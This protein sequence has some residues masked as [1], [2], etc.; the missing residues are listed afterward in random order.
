MSTLNVDNNNAM[1]G[2]NL[3][4]SPSSTTDIFTG[5]TN[6]QEIFSWKT[7]ITH[8]IAR[9]MPPLNQQRFLTYPKRA[10][11]VN[12][13][14]SI[15]MDQE[16]LSPQKSLQTMVLVLGWYVT[17][18]ATCDL[19]S[20]RRVE[21]ALQ[22]IA[23]GKADRIIFSGG[24]NAKALGKGGLI[25]EAQAMLDY[26]INLGLDPSIA[27]L[28]E[29]STCFWENKRYS[30]ALINQLTY[31]KRLA[32]KPKRVYVISSD[33]SLQ[34][35]LSI[36]TEP[37]YEIIPA[38][39]EPESMAMLPEALFWQLYGKITER[40]KSRRQY[41]TSEVYSPKSMAVSSL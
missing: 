41:N 12:S 34:R 35:L 24:K 33:F 9:L 30:E 6:S 10:E 13:F 29:Q 28:E 32:D 4:S 40:I 2:D 25:S 18:M 20:R 7:L 3:N 36:F 15:P 11:T 22:L 37:Q 21:K 1:I 5:V 23:Q 17:P 38:C 31:S 27:Y 8:T 16:T 26:A 19:V 14:D 39:T